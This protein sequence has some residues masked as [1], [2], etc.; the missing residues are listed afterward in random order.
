[1]VVEFGAQFLKEKRDLH[2][3]DEGNSKANYCRDQAYAL[4]AQEAWQV[5]ARQIQKHGGIHVIL[6]G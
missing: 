1:M 2:Q 6:H 3:D 4:I 5:G